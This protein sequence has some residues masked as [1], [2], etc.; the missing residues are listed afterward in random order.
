MRNRAVAAGMIGFTAGVAMGAAFSSPYYYGPYGWY[1][2]AYMYNDAWD[3]YYDARE[4]AREDWT[5]HREDIAEE[6]GDR[7]QNG[8]D[9]RTERA[10]LENLG[11]LVDGQPFREGN[12]HLIDVAAGEP[13]D[14]LERRG[15]RIEPVLA[16]LQLTT[17]AR[18]AQRRAKRPRVRHDAGLG[19]APLDG[20]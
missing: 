9:Q 12:R 14:D 8:Q 17:A 18:P 5:D 1:G 11:H 13:I 15:R 6:R 4:D 16:R 10:H 3:D 7:A 19:E 20:A 2:G